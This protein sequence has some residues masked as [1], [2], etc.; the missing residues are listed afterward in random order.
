ML[1][2]ELLLST[3]RKTLFALVFYKTLFGRNSCVKE[4]NHTKDHN[5]T[6]NNI[7]Q[8]YFKNNIFKLIFQTYIYLIFNL[9]YMKQ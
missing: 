2:Y 7:A 1:I 8:L 5:L 4:V 3:S 6:N 9:Y